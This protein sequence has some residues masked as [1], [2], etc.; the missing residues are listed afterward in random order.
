MADENLD[1]SELEKDTLSFSSKNSNIKIKESDGIL[2]MLNEKSVVVLGPAGPNNGKTKDNIILYDANGDQRFNRVWSYIYNE[3][4]TYKTRIDLTTKIANFEQTISKFANN[5]IETYSYGND[6]NAKQ[7]YINEGFDAYII[8]SGG[9]TDNYATNAAGRTDI[10]IT[11][12][13]NGAPCS[14][15]T[16]WGGSDNNPWIYIT[17]KVSSGYY[18]IQFSSIGTKSTHRSGYDPWGGTSIDWWV[19]VVSFPS[20]LI[21]QI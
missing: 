12:N 7:I 16:Y 21:E 5:N 9:M 19:T 10:I 15:R 13:S 3:D 2:N 14:F 6:R 11:K 20:D 17:N 4:G 8:V 1:K 18:T